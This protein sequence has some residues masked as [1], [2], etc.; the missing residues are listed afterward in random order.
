M[1]LTEILPGCLDSNGSSPQDLLVLYC[2][3]YYCRTSLFFN[4]STLY[5]NL[6]LIRKYTSYHNR[7]LLILKVK[8]E[9]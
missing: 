3:L 4:L 1:S 9:F 6:S 5:F 8:F 7:L 2:G